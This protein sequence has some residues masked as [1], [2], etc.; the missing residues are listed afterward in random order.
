MLRFCLLLAI[1]GCSYE[2]PPAPKNV[3]LLLIDDLGWA[4]TGVYGSIFY[5]TPH[6]DRLA[7]QGARFTQFYAASSVCSPTRASLMTGKHPARLNLTNWIGG[8]QQGP[9]LQAPYERAL[10][11]EEI[12]LGEAFREGGY[13]TAYFGKWHLGV[14][15]YMPEDQGFD[16]TGAV[17]YAGQPG[18]YYPPYK[19]DRFA[20]SNVPDLDGDSGDA[21]LTDRL[22]DLAL[23]YVESHRDSAFFVVLS[24]YAVHTPLESKDGYQRKYEAKAQQLPPVPGP[25]FRPEGVLG[26][27]RQ[28]QDHAAYA[29]MIESVDESVGRI[30]STLDSLQLT[31]DTIVVLVSD[32]GGLSTLSGQRDWAPTSNLPLRAGKGLLYEG[33]I[34]IPLVIKDPATIT[35]GQVVGAPAM[36]TDLYPTLLALAGLPQR[37]D[38]HRDGVNLAPLMN[39]NQDAPPR[40]LHWHFPHYHGSGNRPTGAVRRGDYKLIEWFEDGRMELY[41][42]ASDLGESTDLA[43]Q[44]PQEVAA[45]RKT[46]EDWRKAVDA[47][48]P[49]SNPDWA[50]PEGR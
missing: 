36:T 42:L 14:E 44:L 37:A 17:N 3:I 38:Q 21:Y 50:P 33:G 10:P 31:D 19:H 20:L 25:A 43:D 13:A 7:A 40:A 30:L 35:A 27:T 39:T 29:G 48:M 46:L 47:R 18:S 26:I 15:G 23:S 49:T 5:E 34:R 28:R 41:D 8:E 24:H 32:N 45:L 22:T 1:A 16:H 11:L 12:T 9:L 4:D 6:I 2:Q